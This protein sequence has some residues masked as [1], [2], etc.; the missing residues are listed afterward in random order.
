VLGPTPAAMPRRVPLFVVQFG[1]SILG[2][3]ECEFEGRSMRSPIVAE[4]AGLNPVRR[5]GGS[6]FGLPLSAGEGTLKRDPLPA[7]LAG[8]KPIHPPLRN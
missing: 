8:L 7:V 4:T 5:P 1:E 2:F 6:R 3:V